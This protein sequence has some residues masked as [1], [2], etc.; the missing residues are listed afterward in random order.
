MS[1]LSERAEAGQ[2]NAQYEFGLELANQDTS[3]AR[4]WLARANAKKH[5]G[6]VE[7]LACLND[8]E[9]PGPPHPPPSRERLLQFM[10]WLSEAC[11]CAGWMDG[12]EF[13]LWRALDSTGLHYGMRN[14]AAL[15]LAVLR[16]LSAQAGGWY[17]WSDAVGEP[18]FVEANNWQ[19]IFHSRSV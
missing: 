2:T 14:V 16:R 8:E 10:Q 3:L 9:H 12:L 19:A 17:L 11:W 7:V 5:V 6:A 18:V 1:T 15:E 4:H 13:E